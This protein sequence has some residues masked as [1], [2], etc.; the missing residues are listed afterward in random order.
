MEFE[1]AHAP[2]RQPIFA[3]KILLHDWFRSVIGD[4]IPTPPIG[5][6]AVFKDGLGTLRP[7]LRESHVYIIWR[8]LNLNDWFDREFT[9]RYLIAGVIGAN[10]PDVIIGSV[11][12]DGCLCDVQPAPLIQLRF[13]EPEGD[14]L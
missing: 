12:P 8:W 1:L 11:H 7:D 5:R 4:H 14:S 2:P 9:K 13:V 10:V 6:L 3:Q